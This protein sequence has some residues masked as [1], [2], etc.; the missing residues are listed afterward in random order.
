MA[1]YFPEGTRIFYSTTFAS[2]KNISAITNASPAVATSVAHGFS[3]ND[4]IL[5][6]S[7]WEDANDSV[8][9]VDQLTADTFG[10]VGLDSTDT[11]WFPPGTGVGTASKISNWVEVPQT[12]TISTSGGGTKYGEISPLASRQDKKKPIGFQAIGLDIKIGYDATNATIKAMQALTRVNTNVAA[13]LVI[14]GG[15]RVY[16]YGT[17]NCSEFPELSKG[18]VITL[19]V[20]LGFD[21]RAIPYGA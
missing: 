12:L 16:G 13:K 20:S 5:F 18:N 1:Y 2:P 10:V 9:E 3:D 11:T 21:G 17:L 6:A 15:G 19:S 7:G 14:P 4:P 8:W